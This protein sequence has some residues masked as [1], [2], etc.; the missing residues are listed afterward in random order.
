M[1]DRATRIAT[2]DEPTEEDLLAEQAAVRAARTQRER[3][4]T[5]EQRLEQLHH[6]CAQLAKLS[7]S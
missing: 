1:H 2:A 3:D 5:P 4:L 7:R 6:M